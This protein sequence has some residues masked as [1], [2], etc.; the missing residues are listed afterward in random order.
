MWS[1]SSSSHSHW[2]LTAKAFIPGW[3]PSALPQKSMTGL[4]SVARPVSV[5]SPAPI[6]AAIAIQLARSAAWL[7]STNA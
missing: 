5:P 4:P 7:A 2:C 3:K 6:E 1:P